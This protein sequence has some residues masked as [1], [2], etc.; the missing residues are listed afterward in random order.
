MPA[1]LRLT[2]LDQSPVHP[3]PSGT[4][5]QNAGMLSI[6]LAVIAINYN[7]FSLDL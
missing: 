7:G 6:D 1:A 2:V 4:H 5:I 3:V